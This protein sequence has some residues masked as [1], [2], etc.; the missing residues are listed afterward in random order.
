MSHKI[1]KKVRRAFKDSWKRNYNQ[2]CD[3]AFL[4]RW[5]L[6]WDIIRRYKWK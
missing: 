4:D 2:M 6:C 3:M 5:Q 1:A